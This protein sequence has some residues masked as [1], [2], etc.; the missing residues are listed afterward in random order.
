LTRDNIRKA[1]LAAALV[2]SALSA[3]FCAKLPTREI[4]S[5]NIFGFAGNGD[6]LW[7]VTDQG[8]NYTIA[9]SDTL[10][11]VGY[12][13]PLAILALG[14]GGATAVA[15]LDTVP[16]KKIAKLWYYSH[17][18]SSY[19][20]IV[21][22]F[23]S[24]SLPKGGVIRGLDAVYAGNAFWLACVDGGLVRWDP[25][26]DPKGNSMQAFFP[27]VKKMFY[28]AAVRFGSAD[29]FSV[30]PDSSK[31][32][33]AVGV[34][35]SSADATALYALTPAVLY[36]FFPKDT[37][38]ERLS[39]RLSGAPGAF[40]KYLDLFSS[41]RSPLLFAS[42]VTTT[43]TDAF[44]TLLYRYNW[45]DSAWAPYTASQYVTALTFGPDSIVYLARKP[46]KNENPRILSAF[47]GN[48]KDETVRSEQSFARR[49]SVAMNNQSP[50][51]ISDI[52][53]LPKSDTNGSFWIGTSSSG[54]INNGLFFSRS[55]IHDE[56]DSVPFVYVHRERKIKGGLKESYAYPGILGGDVSHPTR[57][58]FAY[59]LAKASKVS[60]AVYDWNMDLV[61]NVIT[62]QD[63]P[64]GKDDKYGNGRS[65]DREHD[66]W[67]GTNNA[68][69]R[70]AVGVYYF[71]I[72]AQTGERS[73]GKII[74]A[75]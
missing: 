11:W 5:N 75:K 58:I 16:F 22:P 64:A 66:V 8:L 35:N 2:L 56:V 51:N 71:R 7:M 9:A 36:R 74:V 4:T 68:G 60:I 12:K 52:L 6:T 67:D 33:I 63:R 30:F 61:K 28:P 13:A 23:K 53:Y 72:T 48:V 41:P 29:S 10:T 73:F 31:Q 43:G 69:R 47:S 70:V 55:E 39:S 40:D 34:R 26:G 38:W 65:T 14:F 15:C 21:L 46:N 18:D 44:D 62:N 32:V 3:A 50:D 25:K 19:D 45:T 54:V 27:G 20:S 59:S 57:S 49:I 1:A 37:L 24:D 42:I 17:T